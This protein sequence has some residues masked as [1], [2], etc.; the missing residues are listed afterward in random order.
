M[1]RFLLLVRERL[2]PGS[3]TDYDLN[4]RQIAAS[5]R[6]GGCP[7]PY[8]ALVPLLRPHEVWWLNAFASEAERDGVAGAYAMNET[9]MAT[10]TPLV[11][12]KEALR[13]VF[14]TTSAS[15]AP[16]PG[17]GAALELTGAR[18]VVVALSDGPAQT[19]GAVFTASDGQSL[20]M[21]TAPTRMAADDWAKRLGNDAHL[22]QIMP[23]WSVPD[24][25][26]V[27]ADARFWT[28]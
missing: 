16:H 14:A 28:P 18:F 7:H 23:R 26:W 2:R 27:A 15:Q 17:D 8:L 25:A 11:A 5:G 12:R 9:L 20:A 4:E 13:E 19:S 10:L 3:E 22:T 24:P 21:A 6:A 1:T